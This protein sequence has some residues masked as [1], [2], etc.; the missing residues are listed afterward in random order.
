MLG[1]AWEGGR[2]G[3]LYLRWGDFAW[4]TRGPEHCLGSG[5][6]RR[7]KQASATKKQQKMAQ[8]QSPSVQ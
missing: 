3:F 8:R 7:R 5:S 6:L 1:I 2:P 4:D